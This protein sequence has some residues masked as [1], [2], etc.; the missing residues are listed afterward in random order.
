[1]TTIIRSD[2]EIDE[3]LNAASEQIDAG[4]TKFA[5]MTYEEGLRE[6]HDWLIGDSVDSP[7]E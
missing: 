7:M 6:M 4:T 1:M 3:V 5:G 2:H